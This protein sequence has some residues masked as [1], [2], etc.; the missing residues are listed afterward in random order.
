[1]TG[2]HSKLTRRVLPY[3]TLLIPVLFYLGVALVWQSKGIYG[4]TGDEPHYLLIAESLYRDGDLRVENNYLSDTPVHE[5][6]RT[7]LKEPAHIESHVVNGYSIHNVGLALVLLAPYALAGVAGAKIF[8]A[9]IAGL[10]PLLFYR[11]VFQITES[12]GWSILIALT[13]A[14]GLPYLPASNQ[15][16]VDLLAGLITL[17]IV[18]KVVGMMRGRYSSTLRPAQNV[19]VGLLLALLPWLHIRLSALAACLLAAYL[20]ASWRGPLH[21]NKSSTPR[22]LLIPLAA[23]IFS[24][25]ALAAYHQIAFG[26]VA[27]GPYYGHRVF[28]AR[29]IALTF[30]GLHWDMAHGIFMQQPLLILGLFG[31][32]PLV[33]DNRGVAILLAILSLSV[34][35]PNSMLSFWRPSDYYGGASFYGRFNWAVASL[36]IFPLAYAIRLLFKYRWTLI[37]PL[38]AGALLLQAWMMSRWLFDDGLLINSGWPAWAARNF[39]TYTPWLILRMPFFKNVGEFD[40]LSYCLRQPA[41]YVCLL[42]SA[43]LVLSGWWWLDGRKSVLKAAWSLFLIAA[44]LIVS[45]APPAAPFWTIT[46]DLLPSQTGAVEDKSRSASEGAASAGYLIY[47]PYL[48]LLKGEY[49]LTLEYE[50]GGGPISATEAHR[51][52][53]SYDL[54][55]TVVAEM[56]LPPS[57]TNKGRL[58]YRFAVDREESMRKQ[59]ECRVWY[60]GKGVLRVKRLTIAYLHP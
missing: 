47:G 13:L 34:L 54:G 49:A 24:A 1:M 15:L 8:M 20:Y 9:L 17:Y 58:V 31:V 46:A 22:M 52:D 29:K 11:A 28:D 3:L 50:T 32:A 2:V 10:W 30:T 53:L 59:F 27:F 44:L 45:L 41:N 43:L 5:A 56:A 51:F 23:V 4:I 25:V 57:E 60:T 55:R 38:C 19:W 39:Y 40:N 7:N 26:N 36:W 37:L 14:L 16:Y 18:E 21:A 33:R 12:R 48:F 42:V 35:V 6:C